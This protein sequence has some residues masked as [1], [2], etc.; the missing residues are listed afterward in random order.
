MK[1]CNTLLNLLRAAVHHNYHRLA[2]VFCSMVELLSDMLLMYIILHMVYIWIY[3]VHAA[4][5][6]WHENNSSQ[7]R[8]INPMTSVPLPN[9][10]THLQN[11]DLLPHISQVTNFFNRLF[12]LDVITEAFYSPSH[13]R[14]H[15]CPTHSNISK[16]N[17]LGWFKYA[18]RGLRGHMHIG[19]Q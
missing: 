18:K 12:I 5:E 2:H 4:F 9:P 17:Y 11:T 13:A 7:L 15:G 19:N 3:G 16:S 6:I 1:C 14:A 10:P 8:I